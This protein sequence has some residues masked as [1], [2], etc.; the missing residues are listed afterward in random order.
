MNYV[1]L[2]FSVSWNKFLTA[3]NIVCVL[4]K[5]IWSKYELCSKYKYVG[6]LK[7]KSKTRYKQ[8]QND[9]KHKPSSLTFTVKNIFTEGTFYKS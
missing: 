4:I 3:L 8:N 5:N 1:S 7:W 6:E 9:K 2:K